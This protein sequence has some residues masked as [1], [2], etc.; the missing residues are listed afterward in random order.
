MGTDRVCQLDRLTGRRKIHNAFCRCVNYAVG[1]LIQCY[2]F[3]A[4][5]IS[6]YSQTVY[7]ELEGQNIVIFID[8]CILNKKRPLHFKLT[9]ALRG[10]SL[11]NDIIMLFRLCA[12]YMQNDVRNFVPNGHV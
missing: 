11:N 6:K 2:A 5:L 3:R 1:T 12:I 8:N 10:T 9:W 4:S 7:E